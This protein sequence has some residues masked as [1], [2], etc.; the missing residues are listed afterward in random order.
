MEEKKETEEEKPEEEKK[1]EEPEEEKKPSMIDEAKTAADRLKAENDRMDANIEKIEKL[2]AVDMLGG[3]TDAGV[4]PEKPEE[5]PAEY[6]EKVMKNE[7]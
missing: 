4:Q 1:E 5:T 6:A 7:G 3:K 2:K